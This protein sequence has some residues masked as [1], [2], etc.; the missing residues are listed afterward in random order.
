MLALVRRLLQLRPDSTAA[1]QA[2]WALEHLVM[3]VLTRGGLRG[4]ARTMAGLAPRGGAFTPGLRTG[5]GRT[6]RAPHG[7]GGHDLVVAVSADR[8]VR[9]ASVQYHRTRPPRM[10]RAEREKHVLQ[11]AF[12]ARYL[13]AG[14]VAYA[15]SG[16]SR[17]LGRAD[18]LALLVGELEAD[19]N[20]GGFSQYLLNKGRRRARRAHRALQRI[21]AARTA[22]LLEQALSK[23]TSEAALAR[24]DERFYRGPEDLAVLA[25]RSFPPIRR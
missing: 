20:N 10:T 23:S 7:G 18:H 14:R 12:Y 5:I 8:L 3:K 22:R 24:L 6:W 1:N 13:A 11:E 9:T 17:R 25:I 19:V 4:V 16:A 15:R 2:R 21:G